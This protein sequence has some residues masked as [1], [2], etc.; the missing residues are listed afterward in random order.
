MCGRC[1]PCSFDPVLERSSAP[2]A[3]LMLDIS[4][5]TEP[6][7]NHPVPPRHGLNP[8][9]RVNTVASVSMDAST[10]QVLRD[11]LQT[12]IGVEHVVVD[13]ATFTVLIHCG[14]DCDE[15]AL[16]PEVDAAFAAA[17]A[18]RLVA[19]VHLLTNLS[20]RRRVKFKGIDRIVEHNHV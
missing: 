7:C 8:S 6:I 11:R 1:Y 17:G 15:G 9:K 20:A 4:V 10:A 14:L 16:R 19:T 13:E 12:L 18:D 3:P 2:N 5:L